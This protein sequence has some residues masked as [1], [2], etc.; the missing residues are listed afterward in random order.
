MDL[1]VNLL[2][3]PPTPSLQIGKYPAKC[4]AYNAVKL[5]AGNA[6]AWANVSIQSGILRNC[7][8]GMMILVEYAPKRVHPN[9]LSPTDKVPSV[10]SGTRSIVPATSKPGTIGQPTN[11]LALS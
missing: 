10:L 2:R 11:F 4:N 9:T 5:T 6:A 7:I 8:L 3:L 1:F